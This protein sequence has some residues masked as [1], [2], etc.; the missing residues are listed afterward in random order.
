MSCPSF[1]RRSRRAG[2]T[3]IDLTITILI[4]GI[5]AGIAVPRF[6]QSLNIVRADAAARHIAADLNYARHRAQV[7]SRPN[8]VNFTT[9]PAGYAM[10]TTPHLNRS[11]TSYAVTFSTLGLPVQLTA[12]IQGTSSVTYN[13]FGLP[14][15]GSPL[16]AMT[17]GS[18]TVTS[19]T[20]SKTVVINPQT[21]RASVQ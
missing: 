8:A 1:S 12:N 10:P 17:S 2:F 15:A 19:G 21:G 14:T 18:I 16:V 3:L 7:S 5:V 6:S 4:L 13:A 20:A 11:G 9:S